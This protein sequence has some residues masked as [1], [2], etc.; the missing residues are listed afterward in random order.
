MDSV[1][2]MSNAMG[3]PERKHSERCPT[4][5]SRLHRRLAFD[6]AAGSPLARYLREECA[7]GAVHPRIL[8]L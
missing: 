6:K 7:R 4:P 8:A 2:A 3:S 5:R 1:A